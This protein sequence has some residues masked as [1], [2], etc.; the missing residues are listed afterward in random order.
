MI[1][2]FSFPYGRWGW[3]TEVRLG[4][5]GPLVRQLVMRAA[6]VVL[7]VILAGAGCAPPSI[8]PP[9]VRE[10]SAYPAKA[11]QAG[12][13]VSAD[14]Y[15]DPDKSKAVFGVE[16]VRKGLLAVNLIFKNDGPKKFFVY[17]NQITFKDANGQSN[18]R[19]QVTQ[20]AAAIERRGFASGLGT[21]SVGVGA[22]GLAA[23]ASPALAQSYLEVS[24]AGRLLGPQSRAN[25]FVFFG[26]NKD[27]L[28]TG[29][30]VVPVHDAADDR[31]LVF[32]IPIP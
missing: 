16:L 17:T 11:S 28:V 22:F 8:S 6:A 20:V 13:T 10:A 1:H 18:P 5:G 29:Q 21:A 3:Y 19:L 30:V 12:L 2:L 26:L 15:A 9:A 14:T 32:E 24:L 4:Q 23:R 7:G 27:R 25:G 31:I